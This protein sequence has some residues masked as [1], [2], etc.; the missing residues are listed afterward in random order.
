MKGRKDKMTI[1]EQLLSN[2]LEMRLENVP[3]DVVKRAKEEIIDTIGCMMAGVNTFGSQMLID[4]IKEWGGNGESTILGYGIKAPSHNVAMVNGIFAGSNEYGMVDVGLDG[5]TKPSHV[6]ETIVS[7]ALAIAEQKGLSGKELL[8]AVIMGED[9]TSRMLVA[10]NSRVAHDGGG[11]AN[12]TFVAVA[13]AGRLWGLNKEQLLNAFGIA[14][15]QMGGAGVALG[16]KSPCWKLAHG[17]SAQHGVFSVRL[18]S[19]GFLGLRDPFFGGGGFF[20]LFSPAFNPEILVKDIGKK[21]AGSTVFKPWPQCRGT[22][23]ATECAM[24]IVTEHHIKA[25]DVAEV[26]VIL[27]TRGILMLIEPFRMGWYPP[28]NAH[29]SLQ[30]IMANILLR[31]NPRPEHY[32][33]EAIRDPKIAELMK[34]VTFSTCDWPNEI[35]ISATVRM[36]MKNGDEFSEHVNVPLGDEFVHPLSKEAKVEKYM[37]GAKFSGKVSNANAEKALKLLEKLE[38]VEDLSKIINLL[39]SSK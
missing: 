28:L 29:Y 32:T 18:A 23:G 2:I 16:D 35:F 37:A 15:H 39:V 6:P 27:N 4:L 14:L 24:K 22:N 11:A 9:F 33:E 1:T 7:T 3:K 34:K 36:K 13:I 10:Q 38:E 25:D 5:M 19:K 21:F 20:T 31:G 30:Y 17:L 12:K 8:T 26:N